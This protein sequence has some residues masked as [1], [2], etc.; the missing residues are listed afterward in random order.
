MSAAVADAKGETE[1]KDMG[2]TKKAVGTDDVQLL[3]S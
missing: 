1:G 2:K 3:N